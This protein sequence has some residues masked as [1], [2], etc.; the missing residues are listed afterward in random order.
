MTRTWM[1]L[2][3]R[4]QPCVCEARGPVSNAKNGKKR[5]LIDAKDQNSGLKVKTQNLYLRTCNF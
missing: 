3:M 2:S 1:E 5:K 4:A